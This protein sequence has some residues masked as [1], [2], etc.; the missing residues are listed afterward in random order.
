VL[1][2]L[3]GKYSLSVGTATMDLAVGVVTVHVQCVC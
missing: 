3:G 2:T 1:R